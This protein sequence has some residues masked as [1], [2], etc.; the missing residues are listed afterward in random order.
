MFPGK[1][2]LSLYL[3]VGATDWFFLS[4]RSIIAL[5]SREIAQKVERMS[6]RIE[7]TNSGSGT[8]IERQGNTY[9]VLTN[10]HVVTTEGNYTVTTFD[11]KSYPIRYDLTR[12]L[13]DVDLAVITFTS[14]RD[15]PTATIGD[16]EQITKGEEIS[17]ASYPDPSVII[18]ERQYIPF[19]F[20]LLTKDGNNSQGYQLIMDEGSTNGSSGGGLF[21]RNGNLIGVN[22]QSFQDGNTG[23]L[24]GRG[25]PISTYLNNR[26]NFISPP[27]LEIATN[28]QNNN[29]NNFPDLPLPTSAKPISPEISV[30][31][32]LITVRIDGPTTNSGY[33][34]TGS[35][36]IIKKEGNNYTVLTT[37]HVIETKGEYKIT[38]ADGKE[39]KIAT[40]KIKSMPNID[41]A[42]LEFSSS[43]G[44]QVA[45]ISSTQTITE[46]QQVYISGYPDPIGSFMARR[47][48]FFQ[49]A[50][51]I[52]W[53][54]NNQDGYDILH[55]NP[56]LPGSSGGP[57]LD[58]RGYLIGINGLSFYDG[59]T[60]KSLG[61]GIPIEL[62]ATRQNSL[63]AISTDNSSHN[64][65]SPQG[66]VPT[67]NVSL[68]SGKKYACADRQGIATTVVKTAR[69]TIP[70]I[71]WRS[72][73]D[74]LTARE[75]C[76][77]V[78]QRF[79]KFSDEN[80]LK[81][82]I[83]GTINQQ[84][85]ICAGVDRQGS[86]NSNNLLF[87]LPEAKNAE[88]IARKLIDTR[89]LGVSVIK[90]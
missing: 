61:A 82:L 51:I 37:R 79:Q 2:L 7:G 80:K 20:K 17:L 5:E 56:M 42:I 30:K 57:I 84:Q 77:Q 68:T 35:G 88:E 53:L 44:Y 8:I 33:N 87:T 55:N 45:E 66:S 90:I 46:G 64:N 47:N 34:V 86:C 40:Q 4:P 36:V 49:E 73:Y 32:K 41:I 26:N 24:F 39:Y 19:T 18:P 62:F 43:E 27:N 60:Q 1:Y 9:R 23:K 52:S 78:S 38:T 75:R 15:Y 54:D 11:G 21:D 65:S 89:S 76:I 29:Q 28:N 10:W 12:Y 6:V 72:D 67:T 69:G 13:L 14:N 48:F 74:G 83:T 22:G 85:A 71:E 16:L 81:Y 31:S 70:I 58:D 59:N 63:I 25:I 50:T 3:V